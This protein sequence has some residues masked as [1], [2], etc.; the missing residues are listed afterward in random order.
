[1]PIL[2]KLENLDKQQLEEKRTKLSYG[3][4]SMLE[5]RGQ[6]LEEIKVKEEISKD[7]DDE[8]LKTEFEGM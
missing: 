2:D 1:M 7:K 6:L 3:E 4:S 5:I 8:A